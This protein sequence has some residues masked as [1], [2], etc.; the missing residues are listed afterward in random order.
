MVE[1][2]P[3]SGV[4]HRHRLFAPYLIHQIKREGEGGKKKSISRTR[5]HPLFL[6]LCLFEANKH[7]DDDVSCLTLFIMIVQSPSYGDNH[8]IP[9]PVLFAQRLPPFPFTLAGRVNA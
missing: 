2:L 3:F 7:D 5:F 1:G 9:A 8:V 6:L 4:H